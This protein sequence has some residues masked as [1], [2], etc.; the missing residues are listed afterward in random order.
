MSHDRIGYICD[1]KEL[2][3][4]FHHTITKCRLFVKW[5]ADRQMTDC[6]VYIYTVIIYSYDV[7]HNFVEKWLNK[8]VG[9][10]NSNASTC[11]AFLSV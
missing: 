3:E 6:P 2:W 11:Q 5:P 7:R 8:S 4:H 9:N 10:A 1:A